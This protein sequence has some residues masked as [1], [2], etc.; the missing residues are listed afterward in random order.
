MNAG[1]PL[2]TYVPRFFTERLLMQL[3]ATPKTVVTYRDAFL[4]FLRF[5]SERTGRNAKELGVEDVDANLVERFLTFCEEERGNSA[6]SNNTR[7]SAI[8]SFFRYVAESE[9]QLQ[10]HCLA[11]L[12]IPGKPYKK[13]VGDYLT[14]EE[15]Q[16]LMNAPDCSSRLGRR[17]RTLLLLMLQTGL[18]LSEAIALRL[19]DVELGTDAH[20]RCNADSPKERVTPLLPESLEA[21][22]IWVEERSAG[23]DNPL[24]MSTHGKALSQDAVQRLVRKHAD[25]ASE[26]CSTLANKRVTPRMLRHTAA[27]QHRKNG[28]EPSR[29]ARWLG[30][31][32][33]ET[34]AEDVHAGMESKGSAKAQTRPNESGH[35]RSGQKDELLEFLESLDHAARKG[36]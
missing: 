25:R 11:V 21:L 36:P 30:Y 1:Y 9:P 12:E 16:A 10:P 34:N 2:W 4:L 13:R 5:A 24:F 27:R 26:K 19:R 35:D 28:V 14:G 7:L 3:H 8:R 18:R 17:D 32:S 33:V 31:K 6:R 29:I 23:A 15:M 22:Q 20:V